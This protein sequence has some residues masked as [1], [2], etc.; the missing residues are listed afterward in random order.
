MHV[1]TAFNIYKLTVPCQMQYFKRYY[2]A[3]DLTQMK[4]FCAALRQE[5]G[6]GEFTYQ[7][8]TELEVKPL[9]S[10]DL[11]LLSAPLD[12]QTFRRPCYSARKQAK[13]VITGPAE[14]MGT[15]RFFSPIRDVGRTKKPWG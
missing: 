12:F 1:S 10:K 15:V 3:D 6:K 2:R 11:M 4:Y 13:N 5:G 9:P 14:H 8:F 7:I